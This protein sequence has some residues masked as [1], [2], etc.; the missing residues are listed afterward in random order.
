MSHL[1][2]SVMK[3]TAS[4]KIFLKLVIY[5]YPGNLI[6]MLKVYKT[7]VLL[8]ITYDAELWGSITVIIT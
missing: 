3:A 2:R 6:I 7:R 1:K 4:F 8:K 5:N